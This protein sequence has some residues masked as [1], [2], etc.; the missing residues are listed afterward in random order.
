MRARE[1][2]GVVY[3]PSTGM[4]TVGQLSR[5][6]D[7]LGENEIVLR[8]YLELVGAQRSVVP[9]ARIDL[10]DDDI[11]A[12]ASL[13]DLEDEHLD[14]LLERLL[15]ISEFEARSIR[16]RLRS[17]SIR[18][19]AAVLG[20]GVIA[21]MPINQ[22]AAAPVAAKAAHPASHHHLVVASTSSADDPQV[23]T[24][25]PAPVAVAAA[26]PV[27]EVAPAPEPAADDTEIGDAMW[28]E[29]TEDGGVVIYH[30]SEPAPPSEDGTE[31]H[32]ALWV[33]REDPPPPEG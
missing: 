24:V 10:R 29:R 27:V 33:E 32:T 1:T 4:L 22:S 28:E 16:R 14:D 26:A 19:A 2:P 31:I 7:D 11:E 13:L 25:A 20:I 21:S 23:V 17:R 12:L 18:S 8:V 15:N 9:G 5:S 3:D 30:E 6:V